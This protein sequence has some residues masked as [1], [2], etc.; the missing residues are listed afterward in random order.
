M[1]IKDREQV[2]GGRERITVV[3]ESVD[4]L[5]HLQ[6]VLEP[7]DR[8]AGDTTRRIQRNDDQM[9]DTGGEREHMWVAI[10]VEDIEFHKFANRLRIGGEIV[11][12]SREDQL[13]F[14]HTLNVEARDEI[15]IE[16]RFKPDQEARLEEAEE[17]TENPDVAIA[18]VE[19]GEAHVH[20]VAQYGTEERATIT[21]TTGKGEYARGRSELFEEL[22][23]VLK[24]LEVDAIIL[25]GPGFTKQD[26]YKYIEQ[27]ES[28]L[29]ELITMVD[30]AAVGDRGVHE[31]LKRGAVADVQEETRIESEAEYIDELTRRIADGAK[32]AYGPEQ[33]KK[34]AEFGAIERLLVLDDRLQKERGPDG[35][36]AISVDD[37]V[38]TTEQK[39][40]DVT[41]FSSEFPPGQQLSNLGGIAA[42]LRYRLE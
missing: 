39:G 6:Y 31:V 40:G 27:N 10:A 25:A 1:Q 11:A 9:R 5:W 17:A 28:E 20:T 3:P 36:W 16:K 8:V 2:E 15:S 24:R 41:V 34:A 35:E 37:I 19:E 29:T 32:A 30:T 42:L 14:H 21:G 4:D 13:N 7:G 33:V 12:C 26:A 23:T 18:T 22:A 38:R